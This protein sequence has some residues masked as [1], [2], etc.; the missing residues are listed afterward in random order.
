M[1]QVESD[2]LKYLDMSMHFWRSNA[3]VNGVVNSI[4]LLSFTCPMKNFVSSGNKKGSYYY[5]YCCY[6]I[7]AL[8]TLRWCI[9][10]FN[11]SFI[12]LALWPQF[13]I[14]VREYPEYIIHKRDRGRLIVETTWY[15]G[16]VEPEKSYAEKILD[17]SEPSNDWRTIPSLLSLSSLNLNIHTAL[18]L[19]MW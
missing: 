8:Y 14:T 17:K 7:V 16:G 5:S 3:I 1:L 15:W 10:I 9:K 13:N 18:Q 11:H 12:S 6:Y 19:C 2:V 4:C